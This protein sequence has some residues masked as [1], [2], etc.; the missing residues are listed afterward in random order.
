[1]GFYYNKSTLKQLW[2]TDKK[3]WAKAKW[4]DTKVW[5]YD[6]KEW[7]VVVVPAALG[8]TA[9]IVKSNSR[10]RAVK[11][12]RDHRDL[13]VYDR[14]MGVYYR[15]RRKPSAAEYGEITRRRKSGEDYFTILSSMGLL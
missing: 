9:K 1:M 11:E 14:S 5:L 15:M 7:L 8:A 2:E 4:S 6:N 10:N 3:A 13:D 12:D